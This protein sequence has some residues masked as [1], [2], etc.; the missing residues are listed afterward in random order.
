MSVAIC[1]GCAIGVMGAGAEPDRPLDGT[2]ELV[3]PGIHCAACIG[4]VEAIL[5][6]APGVSDARV[7][8]TRKRAWIRAAP[9]ADPADWIEALAN[10][11]YDAHEVTSDAQPPAD[12]QPDIV[13]HLGIAGFAMMNVML[14]SVAVWSGAADVTRDFLQWISALIALPGTAFAARPFFRNAL[15]ALRAGRLAMDVP[16][17][18]AILLACGMSLYEVV[19]GSDHTWFDTALPLTFFLLAGRYLEQMMRRA[20]R[21]A[22]AD[23][24]ALE[25][26]RVHRIEGSARVSRPIQEVRVGDILWL[27]ASARVPVD[28]VLMD[29]SARIYRSALTG[30]SDPV[31][32]F[33]AKSMPLVR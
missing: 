22:A 19:K 18:L 33:P 15:G 8:L 24:S 30:E 9:G 28:A 26:K 27:A 10:A 5:R 16:I 2:I 23:M 14:L 6:S 32:G 31:S 13:L 1:P 3:L 29:D 7:N 20:V 25:P 17:S 12:N 11:G 4:G 21:S